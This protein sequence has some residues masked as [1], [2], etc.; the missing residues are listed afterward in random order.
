MS[1]KKEARM[2]RRLF[3]IFQKDPNDCTAV[4][5]KIGNGMYQAIYQVIS[6]SLVTYM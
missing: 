5:G 6:P 3:I 4:F 2:A 1:R